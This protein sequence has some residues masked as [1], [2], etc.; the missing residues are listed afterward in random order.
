VRTT[1]A[2]VPGQ[3]RAALLAPDGTLIVGSIP[4]SGP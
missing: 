1:P 4:Q 2:N 3:W